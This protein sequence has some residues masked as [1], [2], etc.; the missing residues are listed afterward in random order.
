VKSRCR[1]LPS[2]DRGTDVAEEDIRRYFDPDEYE[3]LGFYRNMMLATHDAADILG[4]PLYMRS[5]ARGDPPYVE[6]RN[7]QPEI[8]AARGSQVWVTFDVSAHADHGHDVER[9]A[10]EPRFHRDTAAV[11]LWRTGEVPKDL[12]A[13]RGV[14][15]EKQRHHEAQLREREI[16]LRGEKAAQYEQKRREDLSAILAGVSLAANLHGLEGLIIDGPR[17]TLWE[18]VTTGPDEVGLVDEAGSHHTVGISDAAAAAL[19]AVDG[20]D[21]QEP[22]SWPM[23][24]LLATLDGAA[25]GKDELVLQRPADPVVL[26]AGDLDRWVTTRARAE[27]AT[28]RRL[29]FG[30]AGLARCSLCGDLLPTELLVA[31]H[32]KPRSRA[33]SA[34]RHDLHNIL[35]SA[36]ALGC[37]SVYERGFVSVDVDGSIVTSAEA[38]GNTA[39][40]ALAARVRT[41]EGRPCSSHSERSAIYYRWHREHVFRT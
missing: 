27:Q 15:L 35:M 6:P 22:S 3:V 29:L 20:F 24:A 21:L 16:E 38:T 37:D 40:E 4:V 2:V 7:E 9:Y 26:P 32:I 10:R 25:L 36:C 18:I 23:A 12:E 41:L 1:A 8:Y 28:A 14:A 19:S 17:G 34:E 5:S 13:A 31:A 33:T 39:P 30:G 11:L